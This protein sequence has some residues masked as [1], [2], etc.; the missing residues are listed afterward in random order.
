MR[1]A[2]IGAGGVGG[3]FGAALAKAGNDV[4][5]VA[6]D[7]HLAAMRA[8]ALRARAPRL[9]TEFSLKLNDRRRRAGSWSVR[10]LV[11]G[12]LTDSGFV[13]FRFFK[14]SSTPLA[15]GKLPS[16]PSPKALLDQRWP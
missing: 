11:R 6:R 15:A 9:R 4:T 1:I 10:R 14:V 8:R 7:A 5:F 2:V 16:T 3:S 12:M 13:A